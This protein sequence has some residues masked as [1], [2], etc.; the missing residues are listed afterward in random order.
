MILLKLF[1]F[2][3]IDILSIVLSLAFLYV[4]Q[5]VRTSMYGRPGPA[6]IEVPGNMVTDEINSSKI[7][8]VHVQSDAHPHV[9]ISVLGIPM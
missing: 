1:S 4:L 3:S 8:W 9:D 7:M 6:Y 5:A 2:N